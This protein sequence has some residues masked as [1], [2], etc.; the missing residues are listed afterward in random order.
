[1]FHCLSK[2]FVNLIKRH[3]KN[4]ENG[5]YIIY[6]IINIYPITTVIKPYT[7]PLYTDG[8]SKLGEEKMA[9]SSV[10]FKER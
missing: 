8:R 4:T 9:D 3:G 5:L 1:M 7:H 6:A 10:R 2:A